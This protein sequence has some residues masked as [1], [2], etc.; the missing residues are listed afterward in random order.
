VVVVGDAGGWSARTQTAALAGGKGKVED[1]GER[2]LRAGEHRRTRE[3][4]HL[5]HLM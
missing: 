5:V 3:R 4:E 1:A 2:R